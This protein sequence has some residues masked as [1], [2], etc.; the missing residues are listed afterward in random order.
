MGTRVLFRQNLSYDW[1][2]VSNKQGDAVN[3]GGVSINS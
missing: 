2:Q 1:Q 3:K